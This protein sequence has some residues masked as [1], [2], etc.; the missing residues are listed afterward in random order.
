MAFMAFMEIQLSHEHETW[1]LVVEKARDWIR[2]VAGDAGDAWLKK[3]TA[4]QSD[5]TV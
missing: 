1:E 3:A 2:R 4:S 5:D